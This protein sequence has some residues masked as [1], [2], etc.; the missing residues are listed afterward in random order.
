MF[1]FA[2]AKVSILS[3][4]ATIKNVIK[5]IILMRSHTGISWSF[6][7][8]HRSEKIIYISYN[9]YP[10]WENLYFCG[11]YNAVCCFCERPS[12]NLIKD[13]QSKDIFIQ[14]K[15]SF[16]SFLSFIAFQCVMDTI[17]RRGWKQYLTNGFKC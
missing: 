12:V 16:M 4:L 14:M 5:T 8:Y 1:W 3:D 15:L 10:N 2:Y 9:E 7:W 11:L 13:Y 6:H 17:R